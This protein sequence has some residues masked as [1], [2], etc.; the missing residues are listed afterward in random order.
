MSLDLVAVQRDSALLDALARRTRTDDGDPVVG[1]L[2]ALVADVDDGLLAVAGPDA[3]PLTALIPEQGGHRRRPGTVSSL[4]LALPPVGRRHVARAVAAMVVTAAVLSVSGVAA[5]VSGDPLTPYKRV[6]DV[7]RAGYDDVVPKGLVVPQPAVAPPKAKP[8]TVVAA[9]R[10]AAQTHVAVASRSSRSADSRHFWDRYVGDRASWD[11]HGWNRHTRS[12]HDG[13]GRQRD[14]SG[15]DSSRSGHDS[16]GNDRTQQGDG[17]DGGHDSRDSGGDG[18]G[19][20][21]RR[22]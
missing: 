9:T 18:N 22:R 15:G 2:A 12:R 10:A 1:L 8:A 11:H 20:G 6:I 19:S 16:G 7:V 4:P 17:R 14:G 3:A 13:D 5:A 21:D